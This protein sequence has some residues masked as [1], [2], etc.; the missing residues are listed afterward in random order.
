MHRAWKEKLNL[1]AGTIEGEI[2]GGQDE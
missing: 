1:E 2:V